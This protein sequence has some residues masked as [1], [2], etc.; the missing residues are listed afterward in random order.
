[1]SSETR[2]RTPAAKVIDDSA[3]NQKSVVVVFVDH[4]D[5]H[6]GPRKASLVLHARGCRRAVAE[7]A[8]NRSASCII[9]GREVAMRKQILVGALVGAVAI[10]L[11]FMSC[12]GGGGTLG[13]GAI[14]D[15]NAQS[16]GSVIMA[17]CDQASVHAVTSAGGTSTIT[18]WYADVSVPGLDPRAAPHVEAVVCDADRSDGYP[19]GS[20]P[21]GQSCSD[22]GFAIPTT[23]CETMVPR[24]ET[25][26]VI[27]FCGNTVTFMSPTTTSDVHQHYQHAFVRVN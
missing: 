12:S 26:R 6:S 9:S 20:C 15:A 10:Q 3:Q 16:T 4:S 24:L 23:A 25:N 13:D 21:M 18:N 27:V 7:V 5:E 11:A 1:M 17:N 19:Y 14:R 2:S 22:T 8:Q